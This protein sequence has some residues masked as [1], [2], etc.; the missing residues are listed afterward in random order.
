MKGF[1]FCGGFIRVVVR[2]TVKLI[3]VLLW[4]AALS[5]QS[6]LPHQLFPTWVDLFD[7]FSA[8]FKLN[9]QT[10]CCLG[11]IGLLD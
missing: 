1:C 2:Y 3:L 4:F 9:E 7:G 5:L 11:A 8:Y 6:M 10:E